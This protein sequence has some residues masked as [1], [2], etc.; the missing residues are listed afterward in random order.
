MIMIMIMIGKSS[1]VCTL[2]LAAIMRSWCKMLRPKPGEFER[3]PRRIHY[4]ERGTRRA[5]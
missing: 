2:I 5:K 3:V 4:V 1:V